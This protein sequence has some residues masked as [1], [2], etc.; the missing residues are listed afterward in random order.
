MLNIDSLEHDIQSRMQ[1]AHVP[2]LAL[3]TLKDCEILYANGFGVMSVES[4]Q[5]VTPET[6][7]R[8]GSTTKPLTG[9]AA[10]RLVEQG[11]LDL[12]APMTHYVEWLTFS[13]PGVAECVTLRMLLS[14]TSGLSNEAEPFGSRDPQGL[15]MYMRYQLPHL[16][17]FAPPGRVYSY[18]N[19][20][21]NLVGYILESVTGKHYADLM[22]ELVFEPLSMTRSTFDPLVAMTYP[23]AQSHDLSHDGTLTVRHRFADNVAHYPSGFAMSTVLDLANFAIMQMSEGMFQGQRILSPE[24][25]SMMQMPQVQLQTVDATG[26]GLTLAS[27]SYKGI[28]TVGH[29]GGITAFVCKFFLVPESGVAVIMLMNRGGLD[30]DGITNSILDKLLDLPQQS[31]QPLAVEPHRSLWP[32]YEGSYLG[33][34]VGLARIQAV[35]DILVLNLNGKIIPLQAL[36]DDTYFR[37]SEGNDVSVGFVREGTHPVQYI[38]L[39]GSPLR[40]IDTT[41]DDR[42]NVADWITYTGTYANPGLDTY[43]VSLRDNELYIYSHVD[44]VEMTAIPI[45]GRQFATRWGIFEFIENADGEII[46]V[47]QAMQWRFER[48]TGR[49]NTRISHHG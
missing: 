1:D 36:S 45:K 35:N 14:H 41:T 30:I 26:Y 21:L 15:E 16:P 29:D 48:I 33:N 27:H 2:G 5:P 7:F 8:I 28:H 19:P 13:E 4:G 32:L 43:E 23:V 18:S 39:N 38:M 22:H 37:Q 44:G 46:T 24:L 31:S 42:S 49:P 9:T 20:G 11:K 3:C 34:W 47:V 10:M 40:R 6:I 17:M 25:V 12:D